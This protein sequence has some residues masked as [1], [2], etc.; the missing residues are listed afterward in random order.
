MNRSTFAVPFLVALA[1]AGGTLITQPSAAGQPHMRSAQDAL[2][3]AER[4]LEDA[5]QDKGGH[6]KRALDHVRQALTEVRAGIKYDR[7][8]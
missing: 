3:V 4:H 8:H 1:F 6:R 5:S 7:R 2:K